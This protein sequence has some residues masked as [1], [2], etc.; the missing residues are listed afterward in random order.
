[1]NRNRYRLVRN[2]ATGLWNPVAEHA[3]THGKDGSVQIGLMTSLFLLTLSALSPAQAGE[4]PVA[5]AGGACGTHPGV[6]VPFAHSGTAAYGV[7]GNTGTI[8]QVGDKAIVNFRSFN[9]SPGSNVVYQQVDSLAALNP[10]AGASFTNLS[11]IWDANPSVIAGAITQAAG[12]K[13]N[14]ILVNTNGIAFVNGAQVNLNTL[15]ATSLNIA[16]TF[17]LDQ[18]LTNSTITPQFEGNSGFVK[19]LE[20]AQITAGSQGRVMLLAPTVINQGKVSAPD[21]QVIAAAATKV[22]LTSASSSDPNVRGLLIEI[23]S[24]AGMADYDTAN[25]D[26][27]DG[28]LDGKTVKL[29]DPAHDKLGHVTNLGE[30]TATRGNVTMVGLAVNQMGVARATTSVVANGSVYLMAKDLDITPT[31]PPNSTVQRGGRVILGAGSVTEVLPETTDATGSLDGNTGTG[32]ALASQVKVVGQDIRMAGGAT[33]EAPAGTVDLIAIDNPGLLDTTNDPFKQVGASLISTTARAHIAAGARISV[34]GLE[35]VEVDVARN[36]LEVELRGDELKDSPINRN[37]PLRGETVYVDINRAQANADAG[38]STL[39]AQDSL[40]SYQA[41]ITRTAAE[42]STAGGAVNIRSQGEAILESGAVVDLSGGS[43]RYTPGYV[44]TS[45]LTSGGTQTDIA[46]A[47]AEVAYDGI[48]TRFV[49]DYGRWGVTESFDLGQGVRYDP[50]YSEGKNAGALAV[51]GMRAAVVQA[52]VQG[53][54][55]VGELQRDSGVQP[56]GARLTLGSNAVAGDYKLNQR[57]EMSSTAATL[58]AG[59]AF[60]DQLAANLVDTLVLNPA[61]L[62]KDK[63]AHL[64][65]FSNQAAAVHEALRAPQGGSVSITA[66]GV[67]VNADIEAA[68]GAITLNA[69]GNTIDTRVTPIS[70]V[71]ADGVTLSARGNWVNELPGVAGGASEVA[72]PNA[73]KITLSAVNDVDLGADTRVDVI[74]GGRVKANGKITAGKG[75][76]IKLEANAGSGA[77][78]VHAGV[79]KL[80]G[81]G[82]GS[83]LSGY[84]LGKGGKLTLSTGKINIG[85][86]PDVAALNLDADFFQQ[87]GFADFVLAGRDGVTLNDGV[88]ISPTTISLDLQ[89][90]YTLQAT[91]A[92]VE[93]FTRQVKRDDAIRQA[94]NLALSADATDLGDLRI[95]VGALIRVDPKAKVTLN[96]GHRLDIQGRISAPGGGITATLNRVGGDT[97]DAASA[98]WLGSQAVLDVAGVSRAQADSKGLIKGEVVNG[99]SVVLDAQTGFLVSAAGSLIDVSGAAPV[100]LDIQNESGGLGM[101]VGSDAGSLSVSAQEGILLDGTLKARSGGGSNRGGAFNLRLGYADTPIDGGYPAGEKVVSLA[102]SVAPQASGLTPG[103]TIPVAHNGQARLGA[104]ALEAAGFDNIRL[105]GRDAIRLENGL[106][107]GAQ[108]ALALKEVKLD[109]TRIETAGGN[110]SLSAETLRLGNYDAERQEVINTP[111]AGSGT[112]KATAQLLE[113][114]GNFS[115]GGMARAELNGV[116]EIRLAGVATST[117]PRPTGLLKSAADLALHAAL[118]APATYSNFGIQAAGR[119]VTFSSDT[120]SPAMP[121]SAAGS[122]KVEAGDIVQGGNLRAPFGQIDLQATNSLTFLDGSLTSV[123]AD[124]GTV[125]PFGKVENGLNW[126]Y[127]SNSTQLAQAGTPEKSLRVSAANIDMRAGARVDL[128][129]G[130]DLQAYEFTVGPGGSSDILNQGGIYA[131]LP[132]YTGFAPGDSQE[133]ANFDRAAGDAVYL[134]GIPGLAAGVY[135]LLPAHYALLP[136]AWAV[137]VSGASKDVL[138]A[139]TY[140]RADGVQ[141]VAG[142]LTDSRAAAGG[143]RDAR[144]SGFEVLSRAQVL[145]RSEMTLARAAQFFPAGDRPA[146]AGLLSIKTGGGL[147]LDAIYSLAAA[148]GGQGAAVD[149]SAPKLAITSGAGINPPSGIDPTATRLDVDKLNALGADSLFLGGTR[150]ISGDSVTLDVD[151]EFVTLANDAGHAL[152]GGEIILA[153]LDTLSLKAGSVIEASGTAGNVDTYAN[154]YATAGNGALLR[155]AAGTASFVRS[156]SPDGSQGKLIADAG[157]SVRASDSITLDATKQNA[158]AGATQFV[159]AGQ[160]VAGNLA[161]GGERVSFGAAPTSTT[162]L[163]FSQADLDGLGGLESLALTSYS[164]F[165]LYGAVN[166]GGV[167]AQN[168]PIMKNLSLLGAGL[169]GLDNSGQTATLRAGEMLIANPAAVAFNPGGASGAGAL[170]IQ[171]DKLVLGAGDKAIQ[172]Y[173]TVDITAN[174]LVGRGVGSTNVA[175]ATNLNVARVSGEQGANQ[176]LA[177]SGKLNAAKIAA[178]RALAAVNTLGAKW[179]MSGTDVVFDTQAVLPSGQLKLTA[180][181]GTL[182]LGANA[183]VD[184][185]GRT[186]AFYDVSRAAPGGRVEL[187][188]DNGNVELKSGSWVDVSAAPGGDAG[189]VAI[190][191][192]KGVATLAA[193]S[194]HGH[195]PLDAAGK[196]GEGAHFELDVQTLADFSDLN[197][198]LNQ[199]DFDGARSVRVRQGPLTVAGTDTVKAQA[200]QLVADSGALTVKGDGDGKIDAAGDEGGSIQLFS[201]GRLTLEAGSTLSAK[202]LKAGRDG[203]SVVLGSSNDDVVLAGGSIDTAGAANGQD[204]TVTFRAGRFDDVALSNLY[205]AL[206]DTGSANNYAAS[207][208]GVSS[209]SLLRGL[210]VAFT[211]KFSNTAGS[212]LNLSGSGAKDIWNNG[213]AVVAGQIKANETVYLAYDGTRY[214]IVDAAF[215]NRTSAPVLATSTTSGTTTTNYLA[216][217]PGITSYKAGMTLVYTPDADNLGT[218]NKLNLNNLGLKDIKYNNGNLVAGT[219]RAGEPAYLVYD[220]SAFQLA[221]EANTPR[222]TGTASELAVVSQKAVSAGGSYAFVANAAS[223]NGGATLSINGVTAALLKN[224]AS[225]KL[226]DFKAN[227]LLYASYDGGAY[228]VLTELAA[229][230]DVGTGV[231]V[232]SVAGDYT[233]P[234]ATTISGAASIAVEAVRRYDALARSGG[235]VLDENRLAADAYRYLPRAERDGIKTTLSGAAPAFDV[236][237]FH[238]R[239]G[240]EIRY[241]GDIVLPRDINLANY[242]YGGEP[243]VLTV[244]ATGNLSLNNNLSDGFDVAT[245]YNGGTTPPTLLA[246]DSWSY[247]L[248][249]GADSSAADPLAVKAGLGDVALE[250]LKLVRTGTGDIQVAAGHDI[251]LKDNK[252]AIYSAGRVADAAAGFTTPANAQFSQGGGDISLTALGDIT[253]SASSQLY[254][255]WLFRQGSLNEKTGQYDL[256]PAWWVRFDQFQQGVGAL[257]GGDVSVRAGGKVSNLSVSAPT[258]ARMTAAAPDATQLVKTGGGDVRIV[259]GGD[260]LGGQYYADQGDLALKVGGKVDSGQKVGTGASAKPLYTILALGDAQARVRA[261]GDVNIHA[262]LNPHLVV[263]SAGSGGNFNIANAAS[264]NWSLFSTYGDDSGVQLE[265][266]NGKATLQNVTNTATGTVA[267]VKDAYKTPLNFNISSAKYSANLLSVLPPSLAVTAFQGDVLLDGTQVLLSPAAR[268]DLTLLAANSVSIPTRLTMSDME[269]GLIPDA[270]RPGATNN[271]FQ[272]TTATAHAAEPVHAGDAEPVRIYAV[273]GD[274]SGKANTLNLS[275]PEAA[276]VRAGRDVLNL[277]IQAQ[278]ANAGDVSLVEA[279][280]DILFTQSGTGRNDNARIWIGGPGR[281]EVTAGRDIDL[282]STAGIVSRGDLDNAALP[283]GGVDIQVAA[284]VGAGGIDYAGAVGRLIAQLQAAGASPD[285][286]LLWQARWLAGDD[287][288]DGAHAL[289]AVKVVDALADDARRSRVRDWVF[290][291]LRAT[292]R[293][294]IDPDSPYAGDFARGYS[295]LELLFPGIDETYADGAF[296]NYQGG[297]NLFASR[298]KS[299]RGGDIELIVPGGQVVVGLA[300]TPASLINVGNQVLG[301]VTVEEGDIRGIARDDILVNQSRILTVGG[302]DIQL[303]S[304]AGDIDAGKGK[305]TASAVPPPV[306]K[307][308]SQGNVSQELQGAATGSGIGALSGQPGVVAGDVDLIAPK[309]AINAGDAGI[310]AKNGFFYGEEIINGENMQISGTTSGVPAADTGGL[311]AGLAGNSS[312]GDTQSIQESTKSIGDGSGDHQK[313]AEEAK[314]SLAS[315]RPSFISVEVLGFGDG[316]A[317]VGEQMDEA[318][319]LKRE[320]E[321]HRRRGA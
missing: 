93:S 45:L 293:D 226:G 94:A 111:V 196:R 176:I 127:E 216:T 102:Q 223:V 52:D 290:T 15:T 172:G 272:P 5:C 318:E 320:E 232:T 242:R 167:D 38:K 266:L 33:I 247:R 139:Q 192:T 248:V 55:Q 149:I 155:A 99:G 261:E 23:D 160:P 265:S 89:P 75:G 123:A 316:T 217:Q 254:S 228:H 68:G 244:R 82:L 104:E 173:A 233:K 28:M 188:S 175:A 153:A 162:G 214:H 131:V 71:V 150:S 300:N 128:S 63:V 287:S 34:A 222:A 299:E 109:S 181:A 138:P 251:V 301:L 179:A 249:A 197:S 61:L 32:L 22:Y 97:F 231:R 87:G 121:L 315:F 270:M 152:R 79:V 297:V 53:R 169:V 132:G 159:K 148:D 156:G 49:K 182:E 243:G 44:K 260:L 252:A 108:R 319:R 206:P 46:D 145:D 298:I 304:S 101:M 263:Q 116:E 77:A 107:L 81:D 78:G 262:V 9:L 303:W 276:R 60:G 110:A 269:P 86:A 39:I 48:S 230:V 277:G 305:K 193:G 278:H 253:G 321:R 306:I 67:A 11:R 317:S 113:L 20:G 56:A 283:A 213:A 236:T 271:Q 275:L 207:L 174:E 119:T 157:S 281:L 200:I 178:D 313:A 95:G 238:L 257:G 112:F 204:G 308:D 50:G 3:R 17:I 8:S 124:A 205:A 58:P 18:F 105:R 142:Y 43:L 163:V 237:K 170:A 147:N 274:V 268:G 140:T 29:T 302:G 168:K 69:R 37:G 144:W 125:I 185:A 100:R 80:G 284:G 57:I 294:L 151:A 130:G 218:T 208:N 1:M 288:L 309:G 19:V 180:T 6:N 291:A 203:G 256:Q 198:K 258:Q 114:A 296:K 106:D 136:G 225:V 54:T 72:L 161:L 215:A 158:F 201:G 255:N 2:A 41:R 31:T 210:V 85:G 40:D 246:G 312:L 245:Q 250:A 199:G 126:V 135:T 88:A 42:R 191:A 66:K 211:P 74:G 91:G 190:R 279:G 12:Q 129:G 295:T 84:G 209:S 165:D 90:G 62:G 115:L 51:I 7:Q 65:V 186:V 146:D 143:P 83:T 259:T 219:L 10:V 24:P 166:V 154:A 241:S 183:V 64:E 280:R 134:S 47:S 26:V 285:A 227:D 35:N 98:L 220:G 286:A 194:L 202:A 239:P 229:K 289:A 133:A 310:R 184:A 70:V 187:V 59:F 103:A 13:A 177:V 21:G 96:A 195:T 120:T 307:V 36:V 189:E 212:K 221:L 314:Q 118:V 282:G 117:T 16:D 224:G 27:R 264:A 25:N 137:K 235:G 311:S 171:A 234:I 73:G 76:E 122:L 273:A 164:T 30:L 292:G 4:L 92:Q 141:V 267:A 240:T 14:V